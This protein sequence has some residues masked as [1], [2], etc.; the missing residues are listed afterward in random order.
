MVHPFIPRF[1]TI[2]AVS[3]AKGIALV[4]YVFI[5]M[6]LDMRIVGL[7]R[8]QIIVVGEAVHLHQEMTRCAALFHAATDILARIIHPPIDVVTG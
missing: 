7:V 1:G 3:L 4:R 2:E 5:Q 8:Y 6:R